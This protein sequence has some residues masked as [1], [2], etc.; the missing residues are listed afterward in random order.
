[1]KSKSNPLFALALAAGLLA[2]AGC[3]AFLSSQSVGEPQAVENQ[4]VAEKTAAGKT[5]A[6]AALLLL[7]TLPVGG[8]QKAPVSGQNP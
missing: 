5:A 7:R 1:M 2:S 4:T 6:D 8:P 3:W